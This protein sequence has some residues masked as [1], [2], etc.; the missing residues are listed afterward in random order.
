MCREKR[1]TLRPMETKWL[2]DFLCLADTRSFSRAAQDRHVTQSAFSRRIMA[3]EAWLGVP[4]V[5]RSSHPTTLTSAGWL[6]RKLAADLLRDAYSARTLLSGQQ[7]LAD[8]A[9]VVQFAVAHTLVFTFFP[10]WLKQ[11]TQEFGA[12]TARVLAVNVPEG[13]QQ[14][15][16]GD[17]DLLIGYHHPQL[18]ILLDPNRYP[19]LSLGV[20]RMLPFS[21]P[22]AA[23]KP[24]FR[25]PGPTGPIAPLPFMAYSSGAF[26]GNVVEM[27]LLNAPEPYR[28][29]RCFETHMSEALKAMVVAGHGV[30]WLP[31]SCVTEELRDGKLVSAGPTAW[32]TSLEVRLH[33]SARNP[34][35][36]V[37]EL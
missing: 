27:I 3:L 21:A 8:A 35:P 2:E 17:C 19:Y 13:V 9:K 32:T 20:D 23:G 7:P 26:L 36:V 24:L 28:L 30:G 11:L 34:K 12:I 31:E 15:V 18:P 14:L 37:A 16:A 33:R 22:D 29:Q 1:I 5:D 10:R 4:L 6:F 25:L